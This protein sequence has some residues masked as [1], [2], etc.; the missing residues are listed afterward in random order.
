MVIILSKL[1]STWL[2]WRITMETHT[3]ALKPNT[4]PGLGAWEGGDHD[5]RMKDYAKSWAGVFR[6]Q[7][8]PNLPLGLNRKQAAQKRERETF[9]QYRH[10]G[11]PI[12]FARA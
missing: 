6:N 4:L 9:L 10:Y 12:G 5:K 2:S 8:F 1:D 3:P 7:V 11:G